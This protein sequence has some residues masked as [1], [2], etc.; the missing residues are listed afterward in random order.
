MLT[1]LMIR[2][3]RDNRW[4]RKILNRIRGNRTDIEIRNLGAISIKYVTYTQRQGN[5]NWKKI[6]SLVGN[7]RN[8]LLCSKDVQLSVKYGFRRFDDVEFRV[9]LASNMFLRI[10]SAVDKKD[11]KVALYDPKGECTEVLTYIVKYV[12]YPVVVTD[13]L[14]AFS[15]AVNNI[16]EEYG[17]TIQL[18]DNRNNLADCDFILAPLA[19]KESLPLHSDT[20]VLSG[21]KPQVATPAMVYYDY[22]FRLPAKYEVFYTEELSGKYLCGALYTKANQYELGAVVPSVCSNEN[23]A[24]T[25]KSVCNY[26]KNR[27]NKENE[28]ETQEK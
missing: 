8:H 3:V 15:Y 28:N 16:Y 4:Y 7:Q 24:Q 1:A 27:A 23:S 13:N 14:T 22:D 12:A 18:T 25:C 6:N 19:V 9:R 17:A 10:L 11:L 2:D 5:I 21:E 26:L 20:I